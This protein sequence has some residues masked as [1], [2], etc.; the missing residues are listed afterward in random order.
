MTA[1]DPADMGA[2]LLAAVESHC[3]ETG[4]SRADVARAAGIEPPNLSR[5]CGNPDTRPETVR[6]VCRALGL[7]VA[8]VPA[9]RVRP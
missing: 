6:A 2:L 5:A 3:R 8:L 4:A 9:K 7:R 1:P